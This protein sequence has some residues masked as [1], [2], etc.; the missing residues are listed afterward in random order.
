MAPGPRRP[1]VPGN[2]RVII[3][4]FPASDRDA[5][6]TAAKLLG[7]TV[8]DLESAWHDWLKSDSGIRITLFLGGV[9][10]LPGWFPSARFH[11]DNPDN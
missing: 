1:L 2:P 8:D 5:A 6:K 7:M 11:H 3:E 4:L 9:E 10:S